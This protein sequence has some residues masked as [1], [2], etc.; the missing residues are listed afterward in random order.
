M[1]LVKLILVPRTELT[2]VEKI[3]SIA[4][5][6]NPPS[7]KLSVKFVAIFAMVYIY[8]ASTVKLLATPK[9]SAIRLVRMVATPSSALLEP[10]PKFNKSG[11]KKM[12][13]IRSIL[14]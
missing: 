3:S 4:L 7:K 9:F 6:L 13:F 8:S 1:A 10:S 5:S 12:V 11:D 14:S 2:E